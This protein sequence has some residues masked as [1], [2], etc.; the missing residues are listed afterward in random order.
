MLHKVFQDNNI[1]ANVGNLP[2]FQR[3]SVIQEEKEE[4]TNEAVLVDNMDKWIQNQ[5]ENLKTFRKCKQSKS[6]KIC[7]FVASASFIGVLLSLVVL[8]FNR[9]NINS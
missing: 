6:V 8:L 3:M 9:F 2:F 4:K 5:E 1:L 7:I